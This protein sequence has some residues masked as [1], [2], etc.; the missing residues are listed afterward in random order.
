ME[1]AYKLPSI[2][3]N[4]KRYNPS[5][6]L[7]DRTY[8]PN[9]TSEIL[10]SSL[11]NLDLRKLVKKD[12][13]KQ[14]ENDETNNFNFYDIPMF[15]PQ[16]ESE[17]LKEVQKFKSIHNNIDLQNKNFLS[18]IFTKPE[19][20]DIETKVRKSLKRSGSILMLNEM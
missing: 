3:K 15:A 1:N 5:F 14:I 11:K 8:I 2:R 19:Y 16:D 20:N 17:K 13:I 18:K 9:N 7:F 10:L 4:N 12:I 6:N